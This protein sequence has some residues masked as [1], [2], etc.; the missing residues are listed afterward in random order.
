MHNHVYITSHDIYLSTKLY[1]YY[2]SDGFRT[3]K[4]VVHAT[5]PIRMFYN[6]NVMIVN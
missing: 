6:K 3:V 1:L 5:V 2:R 4:Y